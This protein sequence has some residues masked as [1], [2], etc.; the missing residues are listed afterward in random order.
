M[1][2]RGLISKF[3]LIYTNFAYNTKFEQ[4]QSHSQEGMF[5]YKHLKILSEQVIATFYCDR[6]L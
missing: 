6:N 2:R 5:M 3:N 4:N 1:I